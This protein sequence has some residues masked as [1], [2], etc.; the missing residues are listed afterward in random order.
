MIPVFFSVVAGVFGLAFGSFLN[1]CATRW[2]VGESVAAGRS[3]CR[4]CGRTLAWWENLPLVSWLLLRGRCRSCKA[5][6]GWRY[7]LV[8]LAVAVLWAFAGGRVLAGSV[9]L[10]LPLRAL[11]Y[12][13]AIAAGLMIF[14]WLLTALAV[15]DAENLWLP[16][17]LVWPGTALGLMITLGG[18]T[19]Q[20]GLGLTSGLPPSALPA[21]MGMTA[22]TGLAQWLA[23]MG[24]P[25]GSLSARLWIALVS[26]LL[27]AAPML[28][29]RWLY[30][31]VRHREGLGLGDVKLMAMLAAWLGVAG[32]ALA[33]F[34]GSILGALTALA[35]LA[36][37]RA[38][39]EDAEWMRAKLPFGSFLCLGAAIGVFWGRPLIALYLRWAGL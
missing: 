14:L 25:S 21:T 38:Q 10:A 35:L 19:A 36:R 8:E 30:R 20:A 39:G 29:I 31:L 11:A 32:A 34:L 13:L 16:D 7:P 15:L 3:R 23:A 26:P 6:I 17:R 18:L 1:V 2:P 12:Q 27:A 5:I 4:S 24:G 28:A 22:A 33:F 37:P 9:D